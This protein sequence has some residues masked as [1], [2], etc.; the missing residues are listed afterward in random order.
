MQFIAIGG[1]LRYAYLVRRACALGIRAAA[2][3]LERAGLYDI[4]EASKADLG[5]AECV[6]MPNPFAK[7]PAMPLSS[8]QYTVEEL[9]ELLGAGTSLA[10]FGA[11]DVPEK[12]SARHKIIRLDEDEWLMEALGRQTAEGAI[13]M[14]AERAAYELHMAKVLI[15]GYGRIGK[16]LHRMLNGY[17]AEVSV[18][19][20]RKEARLEAEGKGARAV[21]IV[22]LDALLPTQQIVFSTPPERVLDARRVELL[23]RRVLLIDLSSAPYGVDL[24]AAE[25]R[26]LNAW[27]EPALPGRYCPESA[28]A[29]LLTSLQLLMKG[30]V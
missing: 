3:G 22:Q 15:I 6:V 7:G 25:A 18:A 13:H 26:W 1:D 21:D 9:L 30:A 19:A 11:G 16:A 17:G 24:A 12:V 28:G 4:P 10:L 14:T 29:A 2:F 23:N 27:R 5:K 20:R 8:A